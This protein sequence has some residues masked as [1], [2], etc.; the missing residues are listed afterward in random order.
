MDRSAF[1]SVVAQVAPVIALALVLEVRGFA[2]R[3]ARDA[4]DTEGGWTRGTFVVF[5]LLSAVGLV[6]AFAVAI[7]ALANGRAAYSMDWLVFCALGISFGFVALNPI[8]PIL[9]VLTRDVASRIRLISLR[10]F[11]RWIT[12]RLD[13]QIAYV[14]RVMRDKRLDHLI[15]YADLYTTAH[16]V[17]R[18][19]TRAGDASSAAIAS[20]Y[21]QE[22]EDWH[23][24][25]VSLFEE[26]EGDI[27]DEIARIREMIRERSASS[28]DVDRIRSALDA[29]GG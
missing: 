2:R 14:D 11:D 1:W 29:L 13:R 26:R 5:A 22:L 3:S 17:T 18:R 8:L 7:G 21:L 24:R 25:T 15:E 12:G 23:E 10:R 6:V 20:S 4:P 28:G 9:S 16:S 19:A 27:R